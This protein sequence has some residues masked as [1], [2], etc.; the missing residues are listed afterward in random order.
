MATALTPV[1]LPPPEITKGA[2]ASIKPALPKAQE[3]AENSA[4]MSPSVAALES[5]RLKADYERQL[6]AL[7][8]ERDQ[9]SAELQKLRQEL[10]ADRQQL[11][12]ERDVAATLN[13]KF[14]QLKNEHEEIARQSV[15]LTAERDTAVGRAAEFGLEHDAA[16]VR[17]GEI[18][19]ERDA[20]L[21]ETAKILAE[22]DAALAKLSQIA[23]DDNAGVALATEL[24]TERDA[25]V[26]RAT[27]L[28]T[29]RDAAV[30]RTKELTAERDAAIA[31]ATQF[32]AAS[33]MPTADAGTPS[34]AQWQSRA[35]AQLSADIDGYRNT[36][37]T[38]FRERD[39]LRLAQEQLTARFAASAPATDKNSTPPN[40]GGT[41]SNVYSELFP[42]RKK[43]PRISVLLV[44]ALLVGVVFSQLQP[45][46]PPHAEAKTP[47]HPA[48]ASAA[49]RQTTALPDTISVEDKFRLE[50]SPDEETMTLLAP[51]PLLHASTSLR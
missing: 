31:R 4:P 10:A 20:A 39:A 43:N 6:A 35:V 21:A 18:T 49:E 33:E 14:S 34:Q 42:E 30:A 28:T 23:Q 24:T 17:A 1:L 22:R 11:V 38:L 50:T 47:T 40:A 27:E 13:A 15:S 37:Q 19:A 5:I 44:L 45:T 16:I 48:P 8:S 41:A 25:A 3:P 9:A 46:N 51:E 26:A 7:T 29:E 2:A 32:Q 36:I 12:A